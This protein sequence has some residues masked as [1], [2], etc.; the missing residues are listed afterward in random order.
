MEKEKQDGHTW[1]EV[2]LSGR[3]GG[4]PKHRAL[5]GHGAIPVRDYQGEFYSTSA[6]SRFGLKVLLTFD[7]KLYSKN[8]SRLRKTSGS[9]SNTGKQLVYAD[10]QCFSLSKRSSWMLLEPILP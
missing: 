1:S 3:R 8:G 9:Q 2:L 4:L 6:H 5:S 10:R 7:I